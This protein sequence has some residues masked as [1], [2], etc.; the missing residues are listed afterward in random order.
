MPAPTTNDGT[1]YYNVN[2]CKSFALSLSTSLS[3]FPSQVCSEV[4]VKNTTGQNIL[5]YDQ[6]NFSNANAFALSANDEFT[7]RGLTNSN[8]VSAKTVA[9]T[10]T[11]SIRSQFFSIA[12]QR[13]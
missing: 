1:V 4:I 5:I 10:G 13:P 12:V 2:E 6:N 7:F 11:L 3:V 9:G 8:Q